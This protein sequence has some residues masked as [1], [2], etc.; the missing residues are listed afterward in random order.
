[1]RRPCLALVPAVEAFDRGLEALGSTGRSETDALV[2]LA[3][4]VKLLAVLENI[5]IAR[6]RS[7]FD[8]PG[9]VTP[10]PSSLA[11]QYLRLQAALAKD[12]G[13]PESQ[14]TI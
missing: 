2:V 13:L 6:F 14:V 4:D 5:S 10:W 11:S 1:V 9:L 3:L 8:V 7:E 12:L